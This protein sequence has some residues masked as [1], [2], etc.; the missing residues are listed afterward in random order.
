MLKHF[1]IITSV[2]LVTASSFGA[3]AQT[4]KY[5]DVLLDGK[6][7]QLNLI[8]GVITFNDGVVAKSQTAKK[9]KDSVKASNTI[10]NKNRNPSQSNQH[11]FTAGLE[12]KPTQSTN[13]NAAKTNIIASDT[14]T[15][16]FQ[17]NVSN[18]KPQIESLT[19]MVYDI[20]LSKDE[21]K[22]NT[23]N[24]HLVKKG[25]TLY[26]I[27][28]QYNT[29]LEAL[30]KANNLETTLIKTGQ[31]LRVKSFDS[32]DF[33]HNPVWTVSKG[34]TLYNIAKRNNTTVESIKS[35]NGLVSNLIKIGQ[36]LQ[37][38]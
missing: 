4:E 17:K 32:S 3:V 25:E 15:T 6:P 16:S 12:K 21:S 22:T 11:T 9:I 20:S 19:D 31:N 30:K 26:A 28:K 5:K 27:S 38:K 29:T 23:S 36:K 18:S 8:T 7:A 37:L 34:D 13:D 14:I 24:F 33:E 1:K 2:L 35:L 10:I